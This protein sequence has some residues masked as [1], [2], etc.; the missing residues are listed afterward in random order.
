MKRKLLFCTVFLSV[1]LFSSYM[2]CKNNT[3]TDIDGNVYN[4]V[5]IGTQVW[6]VQNL[7]TTKYRN[8]DPLT[9]YNSPPNYCWYDN[10]EKNK[11]TYGALYSWYAVSDTRN[12]APKGWLYP[13]ILNGQF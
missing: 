9:V 7:K 6:M 5:K 4:T 1:I 8:G 10:D 13:R 3:V 12:I 11:S 2:S